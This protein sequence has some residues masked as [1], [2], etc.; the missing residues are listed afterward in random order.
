MP[1]PATPP[2]PPRPRRRVWSDSQISEMTEG[3]LPDAK[4]Q[5]ALH[6]R[7]ARG[8]DPTSYAVLRTARR[9]ESLMSLL[10]PPEKAEETQIDQILALLEAIAA[11]QLRMEERMVALESRL[12]G[13]SAAS[14]PPSVPARTGSRS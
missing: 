14:P 13:R 5:D 9:T 6:T 8:M 12:A 7:D 10:E 4:I 2:N 3:T 1:A 11:A